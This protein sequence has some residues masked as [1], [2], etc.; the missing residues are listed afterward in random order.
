MW[1]NHGLA[2]IW[3]NSESAKFVSDFCTDCKLNPRIEPKVSD[4]EMISK[5][6]WQAWNLLRLCCKV[7]LHFCTSN[8][9]H[10]WVRLGSPKFPEPAGLKNFGEL[11]CLFVT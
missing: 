8:L 11:E 6:I 9:E 4:L 10:K 5:G 3:P 7:N 2:E 1:E